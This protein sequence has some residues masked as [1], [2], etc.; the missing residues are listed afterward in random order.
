MSELDWGSARAFRRFSEIFFTTEPL[1]EALRTTYWIFPQGARRFFL[2]R[3]FVS[4]GFHFDLLCYWSFTRV[5]RAL[6]SHLTNGLDTA[7]AEGK[8]PPVGE[9]LLPN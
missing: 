4:S 5:S 1:S 2:F 3:T 7:R 8:R 6:H 9:P